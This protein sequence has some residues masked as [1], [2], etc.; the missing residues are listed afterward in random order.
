MSRNVLQ[1]IID[2][3]LKRANVLFA[4]CAYRHFHIDALE[5]AMKIFKSNKHKYT[6]CPLKGDALIDRARSRM[7]SYF[8]TRD[9][10]ILFFCDD[11][12]G[13]QLEDVDKIIDH[14]VRDNMDICGAMY[15]QK[16]EGAPKNCLL[17]DGEKITFSKDS[18]PVEVQ[19]L[20]TGFLGIHRKVFEAIKNDQFS[21]FPYKVPFCSD[22]N[23]YPFFNPFPHKLENGK[24]V[25]LSEDW[26][27][28]IRCKRLGFKSWLDPSIFLK[29]YGEYS[30]DIAERV[31]PAKKELEEILPISIF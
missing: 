6:W 4:V 31:R 21:S 13:F 20:N 17:F 18:K 16:Q 26:A 8:L 14:I 15:F 25:Y 1:E 28:G 9:E 29:H 24:W 27:F 2:K 30:Y 22:L 19:A 5:N 23:F 3:S 12:I 10:D 7:A 11:D